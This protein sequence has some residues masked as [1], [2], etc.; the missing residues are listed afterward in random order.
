MIRGRSRSD[1]VLGGGEWVCDAIYSM[2]FVDVLLI[3]PLVGLVYVAS[4]TKLVVFVIPLNLA[5]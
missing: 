5:D 4:D 1:R 2:I 3:P